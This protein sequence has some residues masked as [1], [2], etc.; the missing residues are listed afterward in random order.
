MALKAHSYSGATIDC[1]KFTWWLEFCILKS[2][3][4]DKYIIT[5][6]NKDVGIVVL[7]YHNYINKSFEG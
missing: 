4:W 3:H 1:A 6:S 2:L 5:K 7:D